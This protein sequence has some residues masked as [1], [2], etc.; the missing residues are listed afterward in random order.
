MQLDW[1]GRIV[2]V[3][4]VAG[5]VSSFAQGP[6]LSA[7]DAEWKEREV[8]LPPFPQLENLVRVQVSGATRFEFFVDV[9]SVSVGTDGVVRYSL[10]AR[11]PFGGENISFEGIRCRTR[12]RK[13]YAI[14]H[15]ADRSWSPSRTSDWIDFRV[16]RINT[17]HEALA[18]QYFCQDRS[19]V[20]DSS[21]AIYLLK[22]G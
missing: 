12:E 9:S 21:R 3:L 11:S 7:E 15:G 13:I 10:V 22:R 18:S 14:G 20:P 19:T 6:G 1:A 5:S 17:Y 4:F 2:L 8:Q 16:A